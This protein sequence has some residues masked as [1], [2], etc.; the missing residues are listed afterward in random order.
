MKAKLND[1]G[2]ENEETWSGSSWYP[3]Y[4]VSSHGR[5]RN[6]LRGNLLRPMANDRGYC[7]V[8]LTQSGKMRRVR[9]HRLVAQEFC[10]NLTGF[11]EVN[12]V[13]GD[14]SNNTATNLEW[15]SRSHNLLHKYRVLGYEHTAAQR[16][17]M[18]E[19]NRGH[20]NPSSRKLF[21]NG[22][23]VTCASLGE[24]CGRSKSGVANLV[25]MGLTPLQI[26]NSK[27]YH[28]LT[29]EPPCTQ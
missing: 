20:Q 2:A 8:N 24:R 7:C 28:V 10:P 4:E 29:M 23:P 3:G 6:L 9:L 11:A 1:E 26:V 14:K 19:A 17:V 27:K 5:I 13:D 25:K 15:C 21:L 22:E 16:R 12:H 18:S